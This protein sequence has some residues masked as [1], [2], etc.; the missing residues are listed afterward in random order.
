MR[1]GCRI[2]GGRTDTG[3]V[4]PEPGLST[5]MFSQAPQDSGQRTVRALEVPT[6]P[7]ADRPVDVF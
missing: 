7:G 1:V 5:V 2:G 3:V 4:F 6:I